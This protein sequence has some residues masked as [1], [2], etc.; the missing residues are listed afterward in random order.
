MGADNVRLGGDSAG[1]NLALA[2]GQK[3]N[4]EKPLL[5]LS[6]WVDLVP[7]DTDMP[8]DMA[9]DEILLAPVTV[10]AA[11]RQFAG[12]LPTNTPLI[13]PIYADPKDL[14][15]VMIFTGEKDLLHP[16]IMKFAEAMKPAG[17]LGKL[18]TFRRIRPL[19]DVLPDAGQGQ[20]LGRIGGDTLCLTFWTCNALGIWHSHRK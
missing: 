6:P 13:S 12:E 16:Q 7:S 14:P 1:G 11:G 17:K 18:A 2:M 3:I 19:L 10:K 15:E 20:H 9:N 8:D 5:L 4:I